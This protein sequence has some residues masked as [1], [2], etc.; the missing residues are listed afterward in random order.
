MKIALV[1]AA[2]SVHTQRWANSFA[3][4]GHEVRIYPYNGAVGDLHY[5]P[6][7]RITPVGKFSVF[8][9]F[10]AA[11]RLRGELAA[12]APDIVHAHYATS[13]A[14]L[15]RLAGVKGGVVS[16]WGSEVFSFLQKGPPA[17][18]LL[19]YS[20]GAAYAVTSSSHVM[21]GRAAWFC[22]E[23]KIRVIPFGVDTVRF[24]PQP[25][26]ADGSV[27]LLMAKSL[28]PI[29]G[30]D[31]LLPALAAAKAALPREDQPKL[32][33]ILYG[34]GPYRGHIAAQAEKLGL[35]GNVKMPGALE[36]GQMPA[37][38]AACDMAVLPSYEE[39][40][41]V[42]AVEAMACSRAVVCSDAP[43]LCEVVR[44]GASGLIVPRR[45]SAAFT[46]SRSIPLVTGASGSVATSVDWVSI[47]SFDKDDIVGL[48][49]G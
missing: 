37:A 34:E 13:P 12:F 3:E 6:E 10:R 42:S 4:L 33:L 39:S 44:D 27:R 24:C 14:T 29:Y 38:L 35:V 46:A 45:D 47:I 17:R 9:I 11:A 48:N 20:M 7:V 19:R 28:E 31:T 5:H 15:A 2:S 23:D 32:E 8:G 16:V 21:A 49:K 36:N 40:F 43:G 22:G 25:R 26:E 1:A 30:Y 41:G 18:A